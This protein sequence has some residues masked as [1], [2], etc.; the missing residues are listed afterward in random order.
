MTS[1]ST[2]KSFER[3][4]AK[5]FGG[6]RVGGMGDNEK[7]KSCDVYTDRELIECKLR[8]RRFTPGEVVEWFR[9]VKERAVKDSSFP[10]LC[11]KEKGREG[12]WIVEERGDG[13]LMKHSTWRID[14]D[15]H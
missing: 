8:D 4:V 14:R 1:L 12:Y 10:L 15:G 3:Q 6:I 7:R 11:L 2:W 13:L 9:K 5:D